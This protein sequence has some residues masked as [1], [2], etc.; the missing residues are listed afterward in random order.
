[1]VAAELAGWIDRGYDVVALVPSCALMLKFEWPLILPKDE[2]VRRL[3]NASFD[4]TE[5]VVDIAKTEGLAEG[6]AALEGG[7]GPAPGS[8]FDWL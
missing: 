3:A 5:Y 7:V 8:M 4:I 2:G 6:L 1:M